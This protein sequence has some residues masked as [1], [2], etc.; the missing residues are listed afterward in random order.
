MKISILG[1]G[2]D[3][4]T[5]A[6]P[7]ARRE[8]VVTTME[9]HSHSATEGFAFDHAR[10]GKLVLY[11]DPDAFVGALDFQDTHGGKRWAVSLDECAAV[12]RAVLEPVHHLSRNPIRV[13]L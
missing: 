8:H 1:P 12:E 11:R 13:I 4:I 5:T 3:S 6:H 10:T 7:F 2:I 9:R